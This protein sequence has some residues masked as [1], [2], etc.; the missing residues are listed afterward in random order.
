MDRVFVALTRIEARQI[1]LTSQVVLAQAS[2][3]EMKAK[4]DG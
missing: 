4:L 1:V 3:E 2:I